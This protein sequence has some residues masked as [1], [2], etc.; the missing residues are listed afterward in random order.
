MLFVKKRLQYSSRADALFYLV[1]LGDVHRGHRFMD[2]D[3]FNAYLDW[4]AETPNCLVVGMG[5][6]AECM[7]ASDP[8]LD[9][10]QVDRDYMSPDRQYRQVTSDFSRIKDKLLVLLD[11]NHDYGFW[12]RHNHNYVDDL[13]YALKVPYAGISA[14]IRLSF[15]RKP[16]GK[17]KPEISVFNLYAHHGWTAARTDSYKVKVIQDLNRI[18]PHLN[19]YFMGH[20][21]RLGEGLPLTTLYVDQGGNVRD[22]TERYFFTG[23]FI[24]A[25]DPGVGSYVESRALPP[26][27]L[28]AAILEVKPNRVDRGRDK[29]RPPFTIRFNTLSHVNHQKA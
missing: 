28:G 8:R 10:N 29:F 6:Y 11:G 23:S 18:F 16:E 12:R 7:E 14:Y 1:A 25:Y 19:A 13:A 17:E 26:T 21:H 4:I 22:W 24:K 27:E 2:E 15:E 5:D 3:L 9:Y 20:V